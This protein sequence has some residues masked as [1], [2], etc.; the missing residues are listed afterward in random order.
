MKDKEAR[1]H[2]R[3]SEDLKAR[4]TNVVDETGIDEAALVRNCVE[5]LCDYFEE[6][7]SISIP[8][9]MTRGK[10]KGCSKDVGGSAGTQEPIKM[11]ALKE[12]AGTVSYRK[13]RPAKP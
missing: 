5:A 3:I 7:G 12:P 9:Q 11:I 6:T 4:I 8:M 2:V 1:I 10:I 13:T